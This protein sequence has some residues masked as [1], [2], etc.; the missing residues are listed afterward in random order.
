MS[1]SAA[2][3]TRDPERVRPSEAT[4]PAIIGKT[5]PMPDAVLMMDSE[6]YNIIV[7]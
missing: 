6:E 5:E 1:L 7:P 2:L 3:E 4:T